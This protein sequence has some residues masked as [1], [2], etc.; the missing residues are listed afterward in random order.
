MLKQYGRGGFG[1]GHY[2]VLNICPRVNSVMPAI[3]TMTRDVM[4]DYFDIVIFNPSGL[5]NLRRVERL[6]VVLKDSILATED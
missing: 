4:A 2:C 1:S 5:S 6:G 3:I